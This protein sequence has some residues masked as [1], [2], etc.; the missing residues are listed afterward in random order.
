MNNS[1]ESRC[2]H[3][4][5]WLTLIVSAVTIFCCLPQRVEA[6]Q[7]T[8]NGNN[9]NNANT[10]SVGVG[11]TSPLSRFDVWS[12]TWFGTVD[13]AQM[14]ATDSSSVAQNVGGSISFVGKFNTAGNYAGFARISGIKENA[15]NGHYGGALVFQARVNGGNQTEFMRISSNGNVGIGTATPL[16][17]LVGNGGLQLNSAFTSTLRIHTTASG[18]N[19]SQMRFS[20]VSGDNWAIGSDVATNNGSRDFHF[21]DFAG[22]PGARITV[23]SNTG[24]VG[25]GTVNPT[26]K[27]D[28]QGDINVSGNINAK[29]QDVAEWV[30]S[31]QAIPAGIVVV[32]DTRNSNQVIASTEPYD[33]RIAG[34]ISARPGITLGEAGPNKVLVATTGRVKIKV[35][36]T[37]AS[38]H[39]GDLLVTSD[40]AG[41]AMKSEPITISGRKIH[42]PGTLI[43]KALEALDKGTGEILVLL[44]LQ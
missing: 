42:S 5:L 41:H 6:Q 38:I 27:L 7:W 29:Y 33:T 26:A 22:S 37:R 28:V 15:T 43:G 4:A 10:G 12:G 19:N 44:S 2:N 14:S 23:Q 18:K 31:S 24:N 35:D 21:Y 39:I 30:L 11:T 32:L 9:I 8:T 25:I 16:G 34:V 3:S 17:D 1:E 36:A 20:G 40:R 13:G